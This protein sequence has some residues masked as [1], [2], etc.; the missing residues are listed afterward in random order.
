MVPKVTSGDWRPCGDN[1]APNNAAIPDLRP[2]TH[3][4]DFAILVTPED[5]PK[6]AVTTSYDL[7]EFIRIPFGLHNATQTFQGFI[8][9]VLRCLPF[10][11]AFIDDLMVASQNAEE[12]KEHLALVFAHLRKFDVIT[13]PSTCVLGVPSLESLDHH[14]DSEGLRSLFSK[15]GA[16]PNFSPSTSKRQ[17]QRFLGMVNFYHRFPPNCADLMLPL[18]NML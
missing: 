13:D 15:V 18:T 6:T 7:F 16:V 11:H 10:A 9:H 12:H 3:P 5:I 8:N 4:Q 17:L 1:R 2:V 14:V